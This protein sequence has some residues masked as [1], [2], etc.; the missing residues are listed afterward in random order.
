M[1]LI[2]GASVTLYEKTATGT[3]PFGVPIYS[4][5]PVTVDNVLI[6]QPSAEELTSELNLTG[7]RI[8]YVLG[9]PKGDD[10]IWTD[11]TVRFFGKTFKTIGYPETGI[12]ENIP[13]RWGQNVKVVHYG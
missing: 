2:K 10:H 4:T 6:G 1:S 3:D 8:A 5:T 7:R 9:I 13:L 12:Q 11:T